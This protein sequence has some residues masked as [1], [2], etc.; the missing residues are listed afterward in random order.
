MAPIF[1]DRNSLLNFIVR[2]GNGIKGLVD[3]GISKV[4]DEFVQ[5]PHERIN[6]LDTNFT[7]HIP[8]PIDLYQLDGPNHDQIVEV[9][10]K[11]AETV[12]FFQVVNHGVSTQ[13][14][15]SLKDTAHQFFNQ[16]PEKK[17]IYLQEVNTNPFVKYMSSFAPEKEEMLEWSDHL[18][19]TYV[20][21]A[22]ALKYW[23]E[24]CKEVTLEYLKTSTKM[25]RRILEVLLLKLGVTL[26][27]QAADAYMASKMVGMN[28][29]PKCPN[30]EL[31]VGTGRH[32]DAGTLTVLLQDEVGGLYVKVEDDEEAHAQKEGQWIEI[33]PI[34]GALVI[35]IGDTLQILSNGR[36]KSAE[37]RV[38]TTNT[39]SRVSIPIFVRPQLTEKIK[40]LHEVVERDGVAHYREVLFEE[41]M[42]NKYGQGHV[43]KRTLDFAKVTLS[44]PP[45]IDMYQLD[46]PNHDQ[47]VKVLIEATETIGLFQVVNHGVSTQL[48][49]NLKDMADR[50]FNR[51]PEKK[52]IYRKGA[53]TNPFV[54]YWSSFAPEK[55]EVLE[56]SDHLN[57]TYVGDAE[58]L[59]YWP[60]EC[61][62]FTLEYL[63]TS[64]KMVRRIL[65][66]LLSKLG[67]T[68][69]DQAGDAYMAAKM[70]GMNFYP[71][72]PNPELTV[73]TGR[74]SDAGTLTVLLQDEVGGLYVKVEDDEEGHAQKA[75]QW[76]EIPP[77]PGALVINIGDTLQILSNGR[78]KSAEHRVQ[79]TNTQSRVSIPLFVRPQLTEKI[80]PL[81]QV[82]ERDGVAHYREVLFEEYMKNKCGQGHVGKRTLDFAKVT[83]S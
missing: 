71:K 19:M 65:E 68:L 64:T 80:K 78:Y 26:D 10:T 6:K 79:T 46:G 45:P 60:E 11:A 57:M 29:Y 53:S 13:L 22:E 16:P 3:S 18:N 32:S 12:G 14:L 35:N 4:P 69:D 17:A 48:L 27:D 15:E 73:G 70:V 20:G 61:K 21:D 51:P 56:W 2:E 9:L 34:P 66:V 40:P 23:P 7:H 67:V 76:I 83:L 30:P 5:P 31:T 1:P 55:E 42:K 33:P 74:H 54:K 43:G 81:H 62:E 52:V 28:F 25:V 63:K 36:Y 50:F 44:S 82:V 59:K 39:Q 8:S 72:C 38:R 47:I 37:H 77:I 75:G 49:E 41:Y 58:A 24:E